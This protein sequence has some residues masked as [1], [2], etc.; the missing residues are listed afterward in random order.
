MCVHPQCRRKMSSSPSKQDLVLANLRNQA[1]SHALEI[2]ELTREIGV[3]RKQLEACEKELSR[4]I[5]SRSALENSLLEQ[6]AS[7]NELKHAC[8][9]LRDEKRALEAELAKTGAEADRLNAMLHS[10]G[11]SVSSDDRSEIVRLHDRISQ[12]RREVDGLKKESETLNSIIKAKDRV[13]EESEAAVAEAAE[14]N[15]SKRNDLN[16]ILDLKRQLKE[17]NERLGGEENQNRLADSENEH[18][19]KLVQSKNEEIES[20]LEQ[21]ENQRGEVV[22]ARKMQAAAD[23]L[24]AEATVRMAE[25]VEMSEKARKAEADRVASGGFV[26]KDVHDAVASDLNSCRDIIKSYE[27]GNRDGTV[28]AYRAARATAQARVSREVAQGLKAKMHLAK[29]IGEYDYTL[30][31]NERPPTEAEVAA[32]EVEMDAAVSE[33]DLSSFESVVAEKEQ[34]IRALVDTKEKDSTKF[35]AMMVEKEREVQELREKLKRLEI[36]EAQQMATERLPAETGAKVETRSIGTSTT[37]EKIDRGTE[38]VDS[39]GTVAKMAGAVEAGELVPTSLAMDVAS[40]A[41]AEG[42]DTGLVATTTANRAE[43]AEI[44][45]NPTVRQTKGHVAVSEEALASIVRSLVA[46]RHSKLVERFDEDAPGSVNARH[47]DVERLDEEEDEELY[48]NAIAMLQEELAKLTD[49]MMSETDVAARIRQEVGG[50]HPRHKL[51]Y[52]SIAL[53]A[54]NPISSAL[55]RLNLVAQVTACDLTTHSFS[56]TNTGRP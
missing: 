37:L 11:G 28:L 51:L 24:M 21:I 19:R 38:K 48:R 20:L 25:S 34:E 18:Y 15:A 42:R 52:D 53:D 46:S 7:Y 47:I 3:T 16:V 8:K 5:E 55:A 22:E 33:E 45:A 54:S 12:Y 39:L 10:K 17:M 27:Q 40:S 2:K 32:A 49:Q 41:T 44:C 35:E 4:E 36:R 56:I 13:I 50:T 23:V 9:T 29:A 30:M 6:E 31:F 43:Q 14:A 1:K 26:P